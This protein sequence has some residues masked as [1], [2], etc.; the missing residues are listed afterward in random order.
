MSL[1]EADVITGAI[2]GVEQLLLYTWS[3]HDIPTLLI[4]IERTKSKK[5]RS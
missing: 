5:Y 1:T 3:A 4:S 2:I